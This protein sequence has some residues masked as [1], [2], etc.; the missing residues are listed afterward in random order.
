M[1]PT[2]AE[3]V[4]PLAGY[5]RRGGLYPAVPRV[6]HVSGCGPPSDHNCRLH[7]HRYVTTRRRFSYSRICLNRPLKTGTRACLTAGGRLMLCKCDTESSWAFCIIFTLHLAAAFFKCH[8]LWAFNWR[9]RQVILY[10][11]IKF[12]QTAL[13]RIIMTFRK[14]IKVTRRGYN[15]TLLL[16]K[17]H[18]SII[19]WLSFDCVT[20]LVILKYSWLWL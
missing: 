9:I 19:I 4:F 16:K 15:D 2:L 11:E 12:N 1:A 6:E 18:L 14:Q 10:M 5:L 20:A 7:R 3:I 8:Q 13:C 17:T